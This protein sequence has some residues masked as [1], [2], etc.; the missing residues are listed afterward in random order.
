[1]IQQRTVCRLFQVGVT[2]L[3]VPF[4]QGLVDAIAVVCSGR[5]RGRGSRQLRDGNLSEE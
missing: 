4:N 5:G 1:M 3:L 2:Q